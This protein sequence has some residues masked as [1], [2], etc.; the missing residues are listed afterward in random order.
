MYTNKT[1]WT[2]TGATVACVLALY[3]R[4]VPRAVAGGDS[5]NLPRV[6]LFKSHAANHTAVCVRARVCL[7]VCVCACGLAQVARPVSEVPHILDKN[8][9][10]DITR[11]FRHVLKSL[12]DF[13]SPDCHV[14][15]CPS[16][17]QPQTKKYQI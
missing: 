11:I 13:M 9:F 3:L 17:H 10:P 16:L 12:R 8:I 15:N 6:P 2:L 4:W 14:P 1:C 7:F 5:G